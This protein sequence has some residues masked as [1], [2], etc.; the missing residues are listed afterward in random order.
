MKIFNLKLLL[1]FFSNIKGD[2]EKWVN[3]LR[4]AR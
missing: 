1:L 2:K 4:K 3:G